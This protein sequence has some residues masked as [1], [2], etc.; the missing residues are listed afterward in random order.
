VVSRR[1]P[2][3]TGRGIRVTDSERLSASVPSGA[4]EPVFLGIDLAWSN[5]ARTGLA[6]VD[7]SG[8]LID[9]TSL[10]SDQDIDHWLDRADWA[11]VVAAIDAPL[12]VTN[13]SGMRPCE[14][15]VSQA[16]GAFGAS[17]HT[18][19]L[20]RPWFDPPRGATLAERHGWDL[21]P[22]RAGGIDHPV[23]IEVYP[24][25]AM[26]TLFGLDRVIPYKGKSGRSVPFRQAAF[27]DLTRHLDGLEELRLES[28]PRWA[29]LCAAVE[30]ATRQVDLDRLEDEIDAI[31]CAHLA[32]LRHSRREAMYVYGDIDT[33]YIVTPPPPGR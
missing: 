29:A 21:D 19:N 31:F 12:V 24:H 1:V 7:D 10:R 17:C 9:S 5:R 27:R 3:S 23:C 22:E 30:Q 25:P 14:R 8:A 13:M 15:M 18:S 32:W 16:F 4:A 2:Q 11:P 26:V 28:S 20:S 6:V 33:G